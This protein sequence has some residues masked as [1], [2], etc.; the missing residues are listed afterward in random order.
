MNLDL[1]PIH[2]FVRVVETGSFT[3][4]AQLLKMPKSR[5]SR[6]VAQ[7]EHDLGVQLLYRTTRQI[8]TTDSGLAFFRKCQPLIRQLEGAA[9]ET[10]GDSTEVSGLL[11]LSAP[12]DAASL[13]V[14]LLTEFSRL[15][16][17]VSFD[18]YL[19]D[20]IL[21][22]V[23]TGTDIGLRFGQLRDSALLGKR[24]GE[25]R[26]EL[27]ASPEFLK[28][29]SP[30]RHASD[31]HPTEWIAFTPALEG[32]EIQLQG[33]RGTSVRLKA[34]SRYQANSAIVVRELALAGL[35]VACIPTYFCRNDLESGRL[36]RVLPGYHTAPEPVQFVF[37]AQRGRVP[38]VHQFVEFA[39]PRL[40]AAFVP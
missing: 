33:P 30:I 15:Y 22:L 37:P 25:T 2:T 8:S 24:L 26:F 34:E 35:G 11:R 18:L 6:Q 4:A 13:L 36:H 23:R 21:D 5:V 1:N 7:L 32:G 10:Q 31:L 12:E 40:K 39:A 20:E 28:T 3:Q 17:K 38:K 27:L 9:D 16:P 14:P 19:T 29:R